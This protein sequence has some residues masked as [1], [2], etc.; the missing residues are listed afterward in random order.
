[1]ESQ[2]LYLMI[3]VVGK[4]HIH[5]HFY[6]SLFLLLWYLQRSTT[7]MIWGRCQIHSLQ[8]PKLPKKQEFQTKPREEG[9]FK[10]PVVML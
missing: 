9:L 3:K 1:M 7:M 4:V 10:N 5:G 8:K 6:E 2:A